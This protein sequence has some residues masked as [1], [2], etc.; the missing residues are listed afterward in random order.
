MVGKIEVGGTFYF[1]LNMSKV[2][3]TF[4]QFLIHFTTESNIRKIRIITLKL[5]E[6]PQENPVLMT[7]GISAFVAHRMMT[8]SIE[9]AKK[10]LS[11]FRTKFKNF[12][13]ACFAQ[14]EALFTNM[15]VFERAR[16]CLTYMSGPY[17]MRPVLE[18][19]QSTNADSSQEEAEL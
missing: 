8:E 12:G 18:V 14:S 5:S 13:D 2:T 11:M 7:D 3:H 4:V 19:K 9:S 15:P 17:S 16:K 10:C 1:M 6:L